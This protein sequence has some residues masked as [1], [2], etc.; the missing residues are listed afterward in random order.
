MRLYI[1]MHISMPTQGIAETECTLNLLSQW[2]VASNIHSRL[3]HF[4]GLDI[5]VLGHLWADSSNSNKTMISI[6]SHIEY[7]DRIT[8]C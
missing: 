5:V 4:N 2:H 6:G 1:H 7:H 8:P 3:D